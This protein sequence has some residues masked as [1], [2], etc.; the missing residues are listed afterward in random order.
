MAKQLRSALQISNEVRAELARL[1][2]PPNNHSRSTNKIRFGV[3]SQIR[4]CSRS[5]HSVPDAHGE[6]AGKIQQPDSCTSA[7]NFKRNP[8]PSCKVAAG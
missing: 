3:Q 2:D 4:P 1:F 6:N 5:I 8:A 7:G